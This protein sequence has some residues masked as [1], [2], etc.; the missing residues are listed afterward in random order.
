MK[1]ELLKDPKMMDNDWLLRFH[2]LCPLLFKKINKNRSNFTDKSNI[3]NKLGYTCRHLIISDMINYV[4][5]R[6][7]V[8]NI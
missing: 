2:I 6:F 7:V 1:H 3:E 5:Y 8:N 4:F